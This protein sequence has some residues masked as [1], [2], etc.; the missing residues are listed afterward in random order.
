MALE[1]IE[2]SVE[3]HGVQHVVLTGG[4]PMLFDPIET[5]ASRL[6]ATGHIITIETAGTIYR[7]I[8]CD[9]MSMSPKLAN[10]TPPDPGWRERHEATR[11]QPEVLQR[12][13]D[14]YNYQLKF[15][16]N[17]EE[18]D[19]L[20]EIEALL[21]QLRGIEPQR[22][23]LMPEGVD[24]VMLARRAKLLV[25]PCMARNWRLTPR[26]HIDLFGNTKGT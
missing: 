16:I 19:D 21:T 6:K 1:E 7:D 4:E 18:G 15:V 20:D 9:L 26:M 3:S 23:L 17:P 24:A 12:L 8:A 25:E 22:V 10:S 5:L 13:V 11:L 2:R 14:R